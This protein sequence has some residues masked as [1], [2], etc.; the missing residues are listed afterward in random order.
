MKFEKINEN[1]L[2]IILSNNEL[3]SS[4]NLDDFMKDSDNAKTSFLRLLNE[5][6]EAVGF[7][8]QDYKIKIDAKSLNNGDYIFII[9]KLVKI[10][11]GNIVVKP[12]KVVK[13]TILK[14]AYSVYQF[15]CFA[16]FEEFCRFLKINKINYIKN[17]SKSCILYKYG[18]YY[19]LSLYQINPGYKK[20]A[21]FYSSITEFSRFFSSKDVFVSALEEHGSVVIDNNAILLCQKY[22][23]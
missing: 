13:S 15:S 10:R 9:T 4:T 20:L 18:N 6:K 21:L 23:S 3:P 19:Y 17:L 2:K 7:N 22:Y 1:K 8:T 12:K 11:S 16:N 5:A 14:S